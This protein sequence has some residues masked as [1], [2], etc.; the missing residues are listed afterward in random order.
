MSTHTPELRLA[1][2]CPGASRRHAEASGQQWVS[3]RKALNFRG[4]SDRWR[5]EGLRTGRRLTCWHY[6]VEIPRGHRLILQRSSVLQSES[7]TD[8]DPIRRDRAPQDPSSHP[9][10]RVHRV[11]RQQLLAW[12]RGGARW[13]PGARRGVQELVPRSGAR[14]TA[15][16]SARRRT[17]QVAGAKGSSE[18]GGERSQPAGLEDCDSQCP[19][20]AAR[21]PPPF[22]LRLRCGSARPWGGAG[23]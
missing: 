7:S 22:P 8:G 18:P 12:A 14:P 4:E 20:Y 19:E 3:F 17:F 16:G 15:A 6:R 10:W 1:I 21:H 13:T 5:C 23:L 9:F 2:P 11:S